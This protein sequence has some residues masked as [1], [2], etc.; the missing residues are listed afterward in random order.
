MKKTYLFLTGGLGNQL[1][2]L[3]AALSLG[4]KTAIVLDVESGNPRNSSTCGADLFSIC[5][6]SEFSI[7]GK[8]RNILST[9]IGGH[10]L[11]SAASPA[12]H[13]NNHLYQTSV[14]FLAAMY[15][16]I[17]YFKIITVRANN[18]VGFS[19]VKLSSKLNTFLFGYFQ[20]FRWVDKSNVRDFMNA[21]SA[22]NPSREYQFMLTEISRIRPIIM[23]IRRGDYAFEPNFGVLSQAYYENGL[24]YYWSKGMNQD[25]WAFSDDPDWARSILSSQRLKDKKIKLV[26]DTKLS[27]GEVFDL[28]RFGSAYVIANSS[29]SWWAAYLSRVGGASVVAPKPWF[30]DLPEPESLIPPSWQRLS[31]FEPRI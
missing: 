22:Q 10:V 31:G 13:E 26:D 23:H 1:F 18:G 14:R 3:A 12:K 17:A 24:D 9:K 27:T 6:A 7:G 30:I 25:V 16:S 28:M 5:P 19:K 8:K 20:S 2:Q 11:R 21:F 4:E 29:F 15:F